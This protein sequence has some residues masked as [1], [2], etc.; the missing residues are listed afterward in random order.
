MTSLSS[1]SNSPIWGYSWPDGNWLLHTPGPSEDGL[2]VGQAAPTFLGG[3]L[4]MRR[5]G[6]W[7]PAAAGHL[8]YEGTSAPGSGP[9]APAV[10]PARVAP[11][12]L[13]ELS[14]LA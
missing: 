3:A 6:R 14:L 2:F 4:L 9:P 11:V 13:A 10:P 1:L 12:R 5:L 7:P 8:L